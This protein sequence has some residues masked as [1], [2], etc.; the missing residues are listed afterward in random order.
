[1]SKIV[2]LLAIGWVAIQL[3]VAQNSLAKKTDHESDSEKPT[4]RKV[5]P[6]SPGARSGSCN[7]NVGDIS[8][9]A[10][11]EAY[12]FNSVVQLVANP[13]CSGAHN[14]IAAREISQGV[15]FNKTPFHLN[16]FATNYSNL[17]ID[18]KRALENGIKKN[19]AATLRN[20]PLSSRELLPILGQLS[21]LSPKSARSMLAYLITQELVSQELEG[22][23]VLL[24]QKEPGTAIDTVSTL[25]KFG[26][27]E[28]L[29]SDELAVS[30]EEMA[31][32]SQA[33][34]L[35]KVLTGLALAAKEIEEFSPTFN[36]SASAFKRGVDKSVENYSDE[37]RGSLL[38]AGFSAANASSGYSPSIEAG[39]EDINIALGLLLR[40]DALANTTLR[41]VWRS[42]VDVTAA[43]PSQTALAQ[44]LALSLTTE[45][46]YL[47]KS[48]RD[49]LLDC[50]K[51]H[52]AV[53]VAMQEQFIEAWKI[54]RSQLTKKKMTVAKFNDQK[55]KFFEPWITGMLDFDAT[56]IK[57]AWVQEVVSRGLV[58]DEDIEN[59]FPRFV[60][61]LLNVRETASKKMVLEDNLEST[62]ASQIVNAVTLW[63]LTH[64]FIPALSDWA[65]KHDEE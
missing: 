50:G 35:S 48:D 55:K 24:D 15:A 20:N 36:S 23:K 42:V 27:D 53:A 31:T 41:N 8:K 18:G 22:K 7:I 39:V 11:G 1:M 61:T 49:K 4:G 62:M 54:A 59:K 63:D 13:Q 17:T 33:D 10:N 29:I 16:D 65:K 44:A 28:P 2:K 25:K 37:E 64:T 52:P 57:P 9:F 40:G 30:V 51:N 14:Q 3:L 38:K 6:K 26:A 12:N 43:S 46:I 60:L 47:S 19:V 58:K 32:T 21:L 5:E 34:S 56:S 45:V